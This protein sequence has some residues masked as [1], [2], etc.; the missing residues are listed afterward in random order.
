MTRNV[1][2]KWTRT[3]VAAGHDDLAALLWESDDPHHVP[4]ITVTELPDHRL[5]VAPCSRVVDS[6]G[7]LTGFTGSLASQAFAD[8][9]RPL[10]GMCLPSKMLR[11]A[12]SLISPCP[13]S[14]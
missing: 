13:P 10:L 11:G 9:R 5:I 2:E 6:A 3:P 4:L 1:N 7:T 8:T 12:G 14:G